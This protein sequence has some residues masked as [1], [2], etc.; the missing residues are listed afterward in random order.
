MEH[1]L[2]YFRL[3][4]FKSQIPT[5][6]KFRVILMAVIKLQAYATETSHKQQEELKYSITNKGLQLMQD[7]NL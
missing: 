3:V 1:N 2:N 5:I 4:N 6:F 7:T